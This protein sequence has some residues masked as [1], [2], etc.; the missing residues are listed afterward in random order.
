[1][2]VIGSGPCLGFSLEL[3]A[4][5]K[6]AAGVEALRT[7]RDN[8]TL[9]SNRS[10]VLLATEDPIAAMKCV[11]TQKNQPPN[12][13]AVTTCME[14]IYKQIEEEGAVSVLVVATEASYV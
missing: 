9:L 3:I 4:K 10:L 12:Q 7:L 11:E 13:R 14:S 6:L 5:A 1:M 2:G 8:G